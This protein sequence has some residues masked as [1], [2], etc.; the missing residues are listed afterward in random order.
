MVMIAERKDGRS[1]QV[2]NKKKGIILAVKL[3]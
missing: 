3:S 1:R 2:F